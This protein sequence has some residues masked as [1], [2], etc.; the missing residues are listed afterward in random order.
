MFPFDFSVSKSW[1][2]SMSFD[3]NISLLCDNSSTSSFCIVL[4]NTYDSLFN[5]L[6]NLDGFFKKY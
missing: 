3:R 2:S 4:L 1:K 5:Q 6:K